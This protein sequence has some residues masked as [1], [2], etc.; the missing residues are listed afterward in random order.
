MAAGQPT[1]TSYGATITYDKVDD[2]RM[3]LAGGNVTD[4]AADP[5]L[6][7]MPIGFR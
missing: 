7:P 2:V 6:P 5:P 3:A 4:Y 1:P